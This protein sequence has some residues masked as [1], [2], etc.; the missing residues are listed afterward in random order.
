M[1]R[2]LA[3]TEAALQ[4]AKEEAGRATK[5]AERAKADAQVAR[6]L[7]A[8]AERKLADAQGQASRSAT[9]GQPSLGA[10]L[11]GWLGQHSK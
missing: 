11:R 3:D 9:K 1:A 6:D 4:R 5:E 2:K 7:K 8:Q 10:R